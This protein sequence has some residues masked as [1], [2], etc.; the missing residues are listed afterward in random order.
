MTENKNSS[1]SKKVLAIVVIGLLVIIN[2]IQWYLSEQREARDKELLESKEMELVATFA[3]LDSLSKQLDLRAKEIESLGG[4]S[5]SLRSVIAQVERE[6]NE[7]RMAKNLTQ[8][9]LNKYKEKIE[10]Y[11]NELKAKDAEIAKLKV[12]NEELLSETINLKNEKNELKDQVNNLKVAKGQLEEKVSAAAT[13]RAINIRFAA[14]S[15]KGKE[16][17]DKEF[18]ARQLEKLKVMFNL[19]ENPLAELGTKKIILRIIEPEGSALY[20]VASGSGTFLFKG[21]EMFYTTAQEILF[22]N[23]KQLVVFEYDKGSEFKKGQYK[24]ELYCEGVMIGK[25]SFIVN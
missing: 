2:G 11:E 15:K 24:A 22:D 25:E 18:K 20:N 19:D 17:E 3:K 9:R 23:S 21:N 5:D 12:I 10:F 7:L 14:Y 8:D 1:N 6:K 16:K 4:K 13:L